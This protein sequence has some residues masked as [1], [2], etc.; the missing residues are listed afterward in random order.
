MK[1]YDKSNSKLHQE[2]KHLKTQLR[3]TI[4]IEQQV[5]LLV[6]KDQLQQQLECYGINNLTTNVYFNQALSNLQ[7]YLDTN[8]NHSTE[9][10]YEVSQSSN[11]AVISTN[12]VHGYSGDIKLNNGG[13]I[14]GGMHLH[15]NLGENMFSGEDVF[16]LLQL[17]A[18][19][20]DENSFYDCFSV[21][22]TANGTY[23]IKISNLNNLYQIFYQLGNGNLRKGRRKLNDKFSY[24]DNTDDTAVER[25]FLN[26]FKNL[27]ENYNFNRSPI[28]LFKYNDT[29]NTFDKLELDDNGQPDTQP[30]D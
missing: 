7:E 11:G 5:A 17:G 20:S 29:T 15:T 26:I 14:I 3:N 24:F 18:N 8:P 13:N 6:K 2:L 25:K 16:N 27:S 21:L 22:D 10:G 19:V 12:Y 28:N 4:I 30:C 9:E 1:Q 23:M